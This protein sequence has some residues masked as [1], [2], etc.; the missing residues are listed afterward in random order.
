MIAAVSM[1]PLPNAFAT[2]TFPATIAST[3]P[4]T[5]SRESLLNSRGS[6]K[7]SSTRRKIT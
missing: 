2:F 4:G 6:Q 1:R 5:P 3:R 7:L